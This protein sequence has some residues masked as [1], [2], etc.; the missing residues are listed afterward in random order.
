MRAKIINYDGKYLTIEPLSHLDGVL[1]KQLCNEI[2]FDVSDGRIITRKQKKK[3]FAIIGDI[4]EY[5]GELPEILRIV[6]TWRFCADCGY[7]LFSLSTDKKNTATITIARRFINYLI[8]FCFEWNIPTRDT[9]FNLTDD[10][11]TYFYLCLWHRR[12]AICGKY[13]DVHHIDRIGM[14]RNREDIVHIGL[15]AIA[16]CRTHHDEAHKDE[17]TFFKD[18][19]LFGIVLD[20]KLCKRL[21]LR[22]KN[23]NA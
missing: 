17:K 16:L 13:A 9:L 11:K 3:I 14:G 19:K 10:I 20:E 5:T 15:K 23:K 6:L 22:S 1:N 8:N 18:N 7:E 4:S 2:D 21:N 12:C